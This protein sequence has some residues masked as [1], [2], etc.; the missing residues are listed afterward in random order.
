MPLSAQ[1]AIDAFREIQGQDP[2]VVDDA[3]Q[4]RP[5]CLVEAE[6]L[7]AWVS[8]LEAEPSL[9]LQLAPFCQHLRRWEVPRGSFPEGRKGYIAWRTSLSKYHAEKSGEVLRGLGF[10]AALITAVQRINLK[11]GLGKES[12]AQT[13]E[14]ALCL[15][16][17]EFDLAAFAAKHPDEKVTDIIR[18]TWAKMSERGRELALRVELPPEVARLLDAALK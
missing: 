8:R 17:V 12:D 13:M 2:N 6:R 1:R 5:K 11:K 14:D 16:F 15:A 18:K 10:D 4:Q 9:A 3:G 7:S